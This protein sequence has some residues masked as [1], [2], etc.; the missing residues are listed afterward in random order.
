MSNTDPRDP[1]RN[2]LFGLLAFQNN[3]IDRRALLA[4]FDTWNNDKSQS[5]GRVLVEQAAITL[6]RLAL[7]DGLVA[8]HVEMHGNEPEK[9]LAALTPIGSVRKDLEALADSEV[10]A[11]I[12]QVSMDRSDFDPYETKI[13]SVGSTTSDGIRFRILRP[14]NKGG[15]G[16]VSVALDTELDRSIA[17]KEIREQAADNREYRARFLAE[18][19]IT[20]KLEHPGIIPIYGLGT[21]ADGRPFYAMRLIRG[22]KTGSL[23]DAIERYYKEPNPAERV[24]EFRSL[25]GRFLDV[26]NA[27]SYAHSKGVLHRDLK[28]DN[29]LLGPY[30]ETLVV[31]WGLAKAAGR[32]DPAS[33]ADHVRLN[34]SGS[35]LSPT[36]EGGIFGTPGYAAPEQLTGELENVGQRSD[37]YGLGAVLYCLMTGQAPLSVK[38]I[39]LP[40]LIAKA[41]N[42]D[43]PPPRQIRAYIDKPLEAIC[44]KAMRT[45][46]ADRYESVAALADEIEHYLADE[47]VTAYREPWTVRIRR[48]AK[49]HRTAMTAAAV[50]LVVSVVGLGA[51]TAVQSKAR[52]D[53]AAKNGELKT[54]NN[55]LDQQRK[56]AEARETQAIAAVKRF[57]DT[58]ANEPKLKDTP[59]FEA[60]RKKL[61]K[62]PLAFFRDLRNSLRADSDTTPESLIRLAMA[63]FDLGSLTYEIGDE[64]DALIAYRESLAIR[65]RLVEANP[66]GTGFKA[67]LADS[68]YGIGVLL[69]DS[70]PGEAIQAYEAARGIQQKLVEANPSVAEFQADLAASHNSIGSLLRKT[71]KPGEA[72]QAYEAARVIR[73]KLAHGNPTVIELQADL[74]ASHYDIGVLLSDTGKSGEAMQAFESAR[75]IWQKLADAIPSITQFQSQ[76]ARSHNSIGLVLRHTGKPGEALQA[77]QA[78]RAIR[79]K[80][81]DANPSV[82]LFKSDLADSHNYIGLLLRD[83]GKPVEALKAYE[84][85]LPIREKLVREH[86]ESPYFASKLGLNLDN[87]ASLDLDAKRFEKARVR[88]RQ[89]V[90]WQRKAL[91]ANPKNP[92]YRQFLANHLNHLIEAAQG[93]GDATGVAESEREL[94]K[95]QDSDPAT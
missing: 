21:Y 3:F 50:G 45:K 49:M 73:E 63:S 64:R 80:L 87:I 2:L 34:L 44:L 6:D 17:L 10:Q 48:W 22:E 62:E 4:A 41:M 91:A 9:S 85:A 76:L 30:G 37:V 70:K 69:S 78:A 36:L 67:D 81:A 83:T 39:G 28:P 74:A 23:M 13:P 32:A 16:V 54:A 82:T 90:E 33:T 88:L 65:Q 92:Q 57:G 12:A 7:I 43:V 59:A 5:L 18:A 14:L 84:S 47:P 8:A 58:I 20:G 93:L 19:E 94:A 53:L 52:N 31:D 38:E 26:C 79:E 89:A 11:S 95:L 77:C 86:A 42:G 46:S 55:A 15:M 66:A 71:D 27:L 24:V 40:A 72:M 68:H 35:E 51:I 25:L 1:A 60:L 56:R 75:A 61:L 29:I